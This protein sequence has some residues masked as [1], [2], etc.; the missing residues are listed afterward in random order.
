MIHWAEGNTMLGKGGLAITFAVMCTI[1]AGTAAQEVGDWVLS[2][3]QGS[4]ELYPG[5]V[6]SRSGNAVTI[7]FD[8]GSV[9]TRFASSVRPFDWRAGSRISCQWRDG[10]WYSAVITSLSSDGYSMQIRYPEDG[11][12]ERTNTGKCR[13]R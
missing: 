3:W 6:E 8:D 7:R 11:T 12:V 9:E 5:V 10:N 13:T 1:S 2:P 4:T